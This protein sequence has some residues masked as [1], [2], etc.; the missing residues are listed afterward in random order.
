MDKLKEFNTMRTL[1]TVLMV[2]AL[3]TTAFAGPNPG[4]RGYISFDPAGALVHRGDPVAY[5]PTFCY[6]VLDNVPDGIITCNFKMTLTPGMSLMNTF[7][8]LMPG[9][10]AIGTYDTGIAL[11]TGECMTGEAVV[12]ANLQMFPS[13]APGDILLEPHPEWGTWIDGCSGGVDYFCI[14]SHGALYQDPQPG[15]CEEN[16]VEDTTWGSVKALYR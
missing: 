11:A 9:D 5:T 14:L 4:A 8:N 2:A 15:D 12:V 1:I 3:A 13:G 10:L 6:V 16:P 7:T